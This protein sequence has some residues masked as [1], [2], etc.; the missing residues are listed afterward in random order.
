MELTRLS[1]RL[2]RIE[3]RLIPLESWKKT[4]EAFHKEMRTRWDHF[5]GQQEAEH[6]IQAE[7]HRA[8][9]GRLDLITVL[10]LF[11]TMVITFI[12]IIV[13]YNQTKHAKTEPMI[14]HG[15]HAT[16]QAKFTAQE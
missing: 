14:T 1:G 13:A 10:V 9:K 16:E 5:D 4:S 12:G 6:E 15:M 8:N 3:D 7:R 11:A 2:D